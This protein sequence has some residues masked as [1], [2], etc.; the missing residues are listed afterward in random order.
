MIMISQVT[1]L[2]LC[3]EMNHY[4]SITR[5]QSKERSSDY[6]LIYSSSLEPKFLPMNDRLSTT[7]IKINRPK[8]NKT[9][10]N[11]INNEKSILNTSAKMNIK[12]RKEYN[13]YYK[14]RKPIYLNMKPKGMMDICNLI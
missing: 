11:P 9:Q 7:K 6:D 2:I 10:G 5:K 1:K 4:N 14:S 8:T 3:I 12:L 13:K